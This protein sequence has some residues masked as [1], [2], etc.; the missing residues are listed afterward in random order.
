MSLVSRERLDERC[1]GFTHVLDDLSEVVYKHNERVWLDK[2]VDVEP[3]G[4]DMVTWHK[5]CNA[6]LDAK[7]DLDSQE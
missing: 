5:R 3:D 4:T 1:K 2:Y 7:Q 6:C